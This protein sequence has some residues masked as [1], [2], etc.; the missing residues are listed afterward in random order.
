M[1]VQTRKICSFPG[2]VAIFNFL[3]G[4]VWEAVWIVGQT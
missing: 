1:R 4:T 2:V 3:S